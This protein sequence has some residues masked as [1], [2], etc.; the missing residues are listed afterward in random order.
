MGTTSPKNNMKRIL[1]ILSLFPLF[2]FAQVDSVKLDLQPS[3][4]QTN[5]IQ[6]LEIYFVMMSS[7]F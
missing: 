5:A 2:T 4:F 3:W 6:G 1:L 7:I